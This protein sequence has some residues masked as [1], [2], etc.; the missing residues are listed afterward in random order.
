MLGLAE[1]IV[2]TR[3]VLTAYREAVDEC[4]LGDPDTSWDQDAE[5][6]NDLSGAL[7]DMARAVLPKEE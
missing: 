3:R 1:I 4:F 7:D 6:F 2:E 5:K